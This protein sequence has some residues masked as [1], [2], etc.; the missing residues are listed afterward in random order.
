[1]LSDL[2]RLCRSTV[3]DQ[4][5]LH[6]LQRLSSSCALLDGQI[7]SYFGGRLSQRLEH[8]VRRPDH[9]VREME[10]TSAVISGSFALSIIFREDWMPEDL[11]V[12]VP[13][14]SWFH[15][16]AYLVH[17]EQYTFTLRSPST[18]DSYA[19]VYAADASYS[20][21]R[22]VARL[23][24]S[25]GRRI[26]VI[27]SPTGSA[28]D[29][30]AHFWMTAVM[31]YLTPRSFCVAYPS[32]TSAKRSI[33]SPRRAAVSTLVGPVYAD[34]NLVQKYKSRGYDI[35]AS[36]QAWNLAN[37]RNGTCTAGDSSS[38]PATRRFFGDELCLVGSLDICYLPRC[39]FATD[40]HVRDGLTVEWVRPG[41]RCDG[42]CG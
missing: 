18:Y 42:S 37:T 10:S 40:R 1:M 24:R 14:H 16:V 4:L 5:S 11:D 21:I 8:F 7:A 38:C 36:V 35:R 26:D 22:S 12:Y 29:P 41:A 13:D 9:F 15:M 25:D 34:I 2:L 31:N 17:V 23:Y 3:F 30:I 20:N 28:L 33:L 6:T 27:Q 19:G 32:L 39:P